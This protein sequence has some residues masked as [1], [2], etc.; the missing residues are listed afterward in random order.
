MSRAPGKILPLDAHNQQLLA[1]VR[2]ADHRNP[3][4]QGR[5]N[6]VVI[7]G[8]TAGLVTAAGAAALGAKVAL[9]ERHLLGGDCLN[10][11]CVPSKALLRSAR[12][13]AE[14]RDAESFGVRAGETRVDF[15]AVMARMRELRARIAPADSAATPWTVR[16]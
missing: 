3:Q 15:A 8:G 5:Y 10:V 12:A 7:G 14:V 1:L 13:A 16:I 2:P 6:L 11:G 9:V 4:P